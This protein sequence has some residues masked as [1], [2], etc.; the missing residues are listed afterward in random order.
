MVRRQERYL[1][2]VKVNY[3]VLHLNGKVGYLKRNDGQ[4]QVL[5]ICGL[6]IMNSD[7]MRKIQD[8][9]EHGYKQSRK[10]KI[11][12]TIYSSTN[13]FLPLTSKLF[14]CLF[15]FFLYIRPADSIV[16]AEWDT[17]NIFVQKSG[18]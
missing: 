17:S 5:N 8:A 11:Q 16:P 7:I 1:G 6:S 12:S 14:G 15:I 4:I 10:T 13:Y 2:E 9:D 18:S 3:R